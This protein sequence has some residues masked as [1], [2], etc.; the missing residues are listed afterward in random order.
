VDVNLARKHLDTAFLL[1]TL[2]TLFIPAFLPALR[3]QFFSPFLIIA[4]YKKPLI[5]CIWLSFACGLIVDLISSHARLGLYALDYSLASILLYNQRRNFFPDNLSTLPLMTFFFSCLSTLLLI[6]IDYMLEASLTL[7]W[8]W[9]LTDLLA[10]PAFDSIY[11]FLVFIL[12]PLLIGKR[13]KRGSDYFLS[14]E[15]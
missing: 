7:S 12:P 14:K 10:M 6:M 1:S 15:S 3:L 9:A 11:A 2:A 13:P 5:H 4:F 8:Q